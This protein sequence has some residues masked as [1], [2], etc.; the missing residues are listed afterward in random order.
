[1]A[2][3]LTLK[4]KEQLKQGAIHLNKMFQKFQ[5]CKTLEDV[6]IMLDENEAKGKSNWFLNF[7]R[8]L[9]KADKL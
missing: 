8:I 7:N 3:Q 6:K 4:E 5:S 2:T 1:M 9:N